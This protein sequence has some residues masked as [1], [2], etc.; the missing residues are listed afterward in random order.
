MPTPPTAANVAL[1]EGISIEEASRVLQEWPA[2]RIPRILRAAARC[3]VLL[4]IGTITAKYVDARRR[5]D[6]RG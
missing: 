4:R 1:P 3:P 5:Q 2:A 6:F